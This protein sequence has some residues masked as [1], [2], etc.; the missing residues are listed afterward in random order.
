L[1]ISYLSLSSKLEKRI[2]KIVQKKK[3]R[4]SEE[5]I[6]EGVRRDCGG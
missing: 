2:K 6:G 3:Y 1:L 5:F 4:S